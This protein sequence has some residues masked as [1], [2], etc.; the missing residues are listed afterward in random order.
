M[1]KKEWRKAH[2]WYRRLGWEVL[3][4]VSLIMLSLSGCATTPEPDFG[5]ADPIVLPPLPAEMAEVE[6]LPPSTAA[7]ASELLLEGIEDDKRYLGLA[8]R[9]K[10]LVKV[11][12]C[13]RETLAERDADD[14]GACLR[15][16]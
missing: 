6:P 16:T 15:G 2:P 5:H 1:T 10:A 8:E 11:Y 13:L 9:H 3:T 14:L 7:T 4:V 12:E